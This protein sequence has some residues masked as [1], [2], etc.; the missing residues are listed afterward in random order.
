MR[1]SFNGFVYT[2]IID[3][4]LSGAQSDVISMLKPGQKV[5]DVACGTGSLSM[6]MAGRVSHVSGIDLSGEM[7]DVAKRSADR[8]GI[9]NVTFNNMDASDLSSFGDNE[10]DV[11]VSSMAVHQFDAGLALGI[12]KEMKR[13]APVIILMDYNYPVPPGIIRPVIYTIEWIAGGD[14]Y[15]NFKMYNRLGG[16]DYF[17]RESGLAITSGSLRGRNAFR[18]ISCK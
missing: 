6:A 18:I 12:L 7:I 2:L 5:L 11:A 14:H 4:V 13:I 1:F 9:Q 8:R 10:F 3:P 16:L 17:T 15:R